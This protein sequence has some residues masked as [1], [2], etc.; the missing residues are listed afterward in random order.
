MTSTME[1]LIQQSDRQVFNE[2]KEV[3]RQAKD[4]SESLTT[5]D[6]PIDALKLQIPK[7]V[8]NPHRVRVYRF[9]YTHNVKMIENM[10]MPT[11]P[12][13]ATPM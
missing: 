10:L 4:L 11:L 3:R 5:A 2:A 13:V 12:P 9:S 6:T 7:S 8:R 1:N